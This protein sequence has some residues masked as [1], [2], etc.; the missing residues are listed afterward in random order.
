MKVAQGGLGIYID[1]L[2]ARRTFALPITSIAQEEHVGVEVRDPLAMLNPMGSIPG[3]A[4]EKKNNPIRVR[5]RKIK[6]LKP[7]PIEG[8]KKYF[9]DGRIERLRVN[10]VSRLRMKGQGID[11]PIGTPTRKKWKETH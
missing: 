1:P 6:G 4:M 11:Q 5:T 10:L 8:I 3:V 7:D 9:L 2:F